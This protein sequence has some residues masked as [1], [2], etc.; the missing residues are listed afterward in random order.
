MMEEKI[1]DGVRHLRC[2]NHTSEA[3]DIGKT[4]SARNLVGCENWVKVGHNATAVV[5]SSCTQSFILP[6]NL[7]ERFNPQ[8]GLVDKKTEDEIIEY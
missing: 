1:I 8:T 4:F 7:L 6:P 3:Y 5:C 2:R